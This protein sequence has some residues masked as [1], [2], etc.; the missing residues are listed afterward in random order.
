MED[1]DLEDLDGRALM[2]M[3]SIVEIWMERT[4]MAR[5]EISKWMVMEKMLIATT[6]DQLTMTFVTSVIY[7]P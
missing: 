7:M 5:I 1:E 3:T 6:V 2:R 4:R